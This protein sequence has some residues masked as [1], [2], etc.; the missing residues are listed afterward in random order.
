MLASFNLMSE[1]SNSILALRFFFCLLLFSI[2]RLSYYG[3]NFV[4]WTDY[5]YAY[6]A[7]KLPLWC[8]QRQ[9]VIHC[10]AS[11]IDMCIIQGQLFMHYDP[12]HHFFCNVAYLKDF[13]SSA[14]LHYPK[15]LKRSFIFWFSIYALYFWLVWYIRTQAG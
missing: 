7:L 2:D 1:K 3:S 9:L 12:T 15:A 8:L 14:R 6:I 5:G 11:L 13:D 4:Y 10:E